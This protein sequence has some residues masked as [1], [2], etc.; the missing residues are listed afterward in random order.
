[1]QRLLLV[2]AP[3]VWQPVLDS[4]LLLKSILVFLQSHTVEVFGLAVLQRLTQL[5]L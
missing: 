4:K 2:L 3:V 5:P 1:V